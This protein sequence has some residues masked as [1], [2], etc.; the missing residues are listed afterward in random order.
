MIE[1]KIAAEDFDVF[2]ALA[3]F[4]QKF[5]P[6]GAVCHFIGTMRGRNQDSQPLEKIYLEHYEGMCEKILHDIAEQVRA[7]I[8]FEALLLIHRVG[9]ITPAQPMLLVAVSTPHRMAAF[10]ACQTMA[11]RLK[12]AAPFWKEETSLQGDSAWVAQKDSDLARVK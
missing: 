1:I 10:N 7:E 6:E 4:H 12:V 3:D 5:K 2:A 11:D 8:P 9:I